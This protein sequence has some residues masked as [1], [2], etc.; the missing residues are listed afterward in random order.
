ML[1]SVRVWLRF[2]TALSLLALVASISWF[3]PSL[4][5]AESFVGVSNKTVM[6]AQ[7]D[8]ADQRATKGKSDERFKRASSDKRLSEEVVILREEVDRLLEENSLLK[9]ALSD[10]YSRMQALEQELSAIRNRS[11][12]SSSDWGLV[13]LSRLGESLN[14]SD[15][16][17]RHI[18]PK[19][20]NLDFG[21]NITFNNSLTTGS[22]FLDLLVPVQRSARECFF[23][24]A[25]GEYLGYW[26]NKSEALNQSTLP[27][28]AVPVELITTSAI[29]SSPN[30]HDFS[31]GAGYRKLFDSSTLVGINSFVD[32][33]RVFDEWHSSW[34]WG[35]EFAALC[36]Y[37]SAIDFHFN[38]YGN[39]FR[40]SAF[41][42]A[43][44]AQGTSIDFGGGCSLA[45]LDEK[46]DLRLG[47]DGYR[48]IFGN[49]EWGWRGSA[50]LTT[51]DGAF[52]L[53]YEHGYD[54]ID[55]SYD[56]IG[57]YVNWAFD[58]QNLLSGRNPFTWPEPVFK[59]SR[60]MDRNLTAK[61]RRNWHQPSALILARS[62]AAQKSL[63]LIAQRSVT[64]SLTRPA[65]GSF[66]I[67]GLFAPIPQD[68]ANSA[69]KI[70]V[71]LSLSGNT[72]TSLRVGLGN[73]GSGAF[74]DLGA[75]DV[76]SGNGTFTYELT[77]GQFTALVDSISFRTSAGFT[78]LS[79]IYSFY[80]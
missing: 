25:H 57:A 45:L 63:T 46:L 15:A 72:F 14:L 17:V 3:C 10:S 18:L 13:S 11:S 75:P 52:S 6:T 62:A 67:L 69:R 29:D 12:A 47:V 61:V 66:L 78:N 7:A 23:I 32:L 59:N 54:R 26:R 22:Y 8:S 19:W 51:G 30:R 60:N 16:L 35:F 53:R 36:P 80:Q 44:R 64:G 9:G 27:F 70:I 68:I 73:A 49:E 5:T 2:A 56:S 39:L 74:F 37:N 34:G 38:Q 4:A 28:F 40:G 58:S 1:G 71:Q 77:P 65:P 24:E 43:F 50:E 76:D 79:V 21:F 42:A 41:L 33:S 55:H 31:F 48:F 20:A